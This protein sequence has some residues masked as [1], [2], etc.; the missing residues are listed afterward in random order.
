MAHHGK[1]KIAMYTDIDD[2]PKGTYRVF[3]LMNRAAVKRTTTTKDRKER[4]KKR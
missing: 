3:A 4:K 1:G 2:C